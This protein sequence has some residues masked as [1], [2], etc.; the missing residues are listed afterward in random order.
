[1]VYVQHRALG[2]LEKDLGPLLDGGVHNNRCIP[3][4]GAEDPPILQQRAEDGE[5]V[6]LQLCA[7]SVGQPFLQGEDHVQPLSEVGLVL[8]VPHPYSG[9]CDLVRIARPYAPAGGTHSLR[10]PAPLLSTV[11]Q[12]VV[13]K[14]NV[15]AIGDDETAA[16]PPR[17]PDGLHLHEQL[18]AV[19]DH[20]VTDDRGHALAYDPRGQDMKGE[21]LIPHLD[22]VASIGSALV[23]DHHVGILGQVV[24]DLSLSLISPLRTYNSKRW[25]RST[26]GITSVERSILIVSSHI[27]YIVL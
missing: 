15:G 6:L 19:D 3:H 5:P 16:A 7:Q 17:L 14:D 20:A 25:H 22:G 8:E 11:E 2:P 21:H 9:P 1:M 4:I 24:S 10:P 26:S 23:S 18:L 13:G 12:P 27:S